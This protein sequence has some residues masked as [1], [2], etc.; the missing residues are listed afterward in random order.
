MFEGKMKAITF[1]YDDGF[2][3]DR[4]LVALMNK[5]QLKGT[6][7]LN[8]EFLGKDSP[9]IEGNKHVSSDELAGLYAGHEVA[10]HTLTH[11][12][13]PSQ[14]E[15]EIIRQV[16]E[17]RKNL[18]KYVGYPVVGM[19]YPGGGVNHD[20]RVAE[21]IK[22]KT[23]IQYC[24]TITCVDSFDVQS[25][26]YQFKPTMFH[27]DEAERMFAKAKEFLESKPNRPQIFY[28][29]GHSFELDFNDAWDLLEEFFEFISFK[30]DIFYGTNAQVL[31]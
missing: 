25:D 12:G 26:L 30:D 9:L 19:A 14:S 31:L 10:V 4:R 2:I 28:I 24:R 8:S 22:K 1:S 15:D 16:E 20:D 13:L 11:C 5:Y 29:W 3:Q 6:F 27:L 21:I 17:D 7:N 23:K 18:E